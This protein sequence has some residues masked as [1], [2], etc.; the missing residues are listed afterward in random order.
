MLPAFANIY[1]DLA[2]EIRR[3]ETAGDAAPVAVEYPTGEDG[4]HTLEVVHAAAESARRGGTWIDFG[5]HRPAS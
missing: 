5:T 1:A 3:R 4:L 2:A